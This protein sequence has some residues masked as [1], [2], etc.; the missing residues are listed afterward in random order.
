MTRFL[1]TSVVVRYLTGIPADQAA[2]AGLVIDQPDRLMISGVALAETAFVLRSVYR[3]ARE[4]IVDRMME[5]VRK[6]NIETYAL[7]KSYVLQGLFMCRPSG[8]VSF[9]DAL[10]WAEARSGT[11]DFIYSFDQRFPSDGITVRTGQ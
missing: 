8:R 4:D 9:A 2:I 10:I 7:D 5:F 11:G 6:E 3:V 1:D